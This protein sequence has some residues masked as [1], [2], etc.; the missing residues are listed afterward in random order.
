MH[1][2]VGFDRPSINIYVEVLFLVLSIVF[3]A[4]ANSIFL[5]ISKSLKEIELFHNAK[6]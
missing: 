3:L 6:F 2:V 1:E 4:L 5:I